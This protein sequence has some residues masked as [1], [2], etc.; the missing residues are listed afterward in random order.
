MP[1][2]P[3]SY[4]AFSGTRLLASGPRAEVAVAIKR[5]LREDASTSP[6]AFNDAT[7]QQEDFDLRGTDKQVAARYADPAPTPEP[8][9]EARGR[10]RPRLGVIAREVT[11]LPEHWE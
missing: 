1:D 5:A 6:L 7:G 2:S 11:L 8:P 9:P 4:T 10:G 3:S